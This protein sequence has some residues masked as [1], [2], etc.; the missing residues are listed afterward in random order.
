MAKIK[1]PPVIPN[2]VYPLTVVNCEE[3]KGEYG[4]QF[5]FTFS[6]DSK[7]PALA[8]ASMVYFTSTVASP[9]SKLGK[10]LAVLG[11]DEVDDTDSMIGASCMGVIERD[12]EYSKITKLFAQEGEDEADPGEDEAA[13]AEA[14]PGETDETATGSDIPF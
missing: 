9:K 8:G 13:E 4:E 7:K 11:L 1:H 14:D 2:G 6:L 12:G 5:K 3:T 10:L